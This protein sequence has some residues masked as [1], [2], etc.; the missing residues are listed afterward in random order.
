[1]IRVFI[2]CFFVCVIGLAFGWVANH[3]GVFV[4]TFLHLRFSVS[5]LTVLC[6]L[7]LFLGILALL[8][9]FL[10]VLFLVPSA[11][12]HYFYQRHQK[13]G[14]QALS[15]GI[16]AVFAGDGVLAQQ[17]EA[18]VAKYLAGK[19]E[20]LAKLLQAQTLSLQ[21]NSASAISLYE[22]MRKE[23]STKLAGLYGL[24]REALKSKAYEAAQQ[25]A[26]EALA[27]SPALLWAHQAVLDRLSV[28]G[29]WD[30]ALA[31]FER[32]QK[33]LP[34]ST[35]STAER[36]HIQAL[37]FS[38]QALHLF[39]THPVAARAAILKAHK[40]VPDFVPIIV[41]AADILYKLN[42]M[43]KA[44]KMIITAWKKE[45]HPDL[46]ALYLEREKGAV[47]RLK[48]AKT[49]ASYNKDT[50]EAAF[51]IAKAALD[52]GETVLAKEQAEKAL[53]YHPRESVYL[54]L[55][56][57]EEAQENN[58]GAVRQLLSLALRAERDPVWMC[59]GVVFP[60]WSVVSPISGRLGCFEWKAPPYLPP[61]TLEAT[62]IVSK[63]QDEE[64]IVEKSADVEV[65]ILEELPPVEDT[66]LHHP[67][68][69]KQDT[70]DQDIKIF[71]KVHLN[72]DDPGIKTEE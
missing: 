54:L 9:W 16:L 51:L 21:N 4:I 38:G 43:R 7:I 60:S 13:R 36:Q 2:Y 62:D 42:E 69:K 30:K 67:Q 44:D 63:K 32:A 40:L 59:D 71:N 29:R 12:S 11:L 28:E 68:V 26:E 37:L 34:R 17:M 47:G 6:A 14:Y 70:E 15:Q 50:F 23:T 33:A 39:E 31:V 61:L 5:F 1:M 24:F 3:N 56:D 49:L 27:L 45:P 58:Q 10:S 64:D 46:A 55:A 57:I 19:Q 18:R 65:K 35:R 8:W 25:Y 41:I 72:V 48:R 52:A 66:L 22:E 53:Q 20:P